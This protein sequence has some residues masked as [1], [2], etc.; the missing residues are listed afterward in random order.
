MI[1]LS[2]L[3]KL[4]AA[5]FFVVTFQV[6]LSKIGW[7]HFGTI[8]FLIVLN[9]I[10]FFLFLSYHTSTKYL[11]QIWAGS[12]ALLAIL[13]GVIA[14]F[15]ANPQTQFALGYVSIILT[16]ITYY[17]YSLSHG[18]TGSFV[19]LLL[20][21]TNL[22]WSWIRNL[23]KLLTQTKPRLV[24]WM[25]VVFA[26]LVFLYTTV[27]I[28]SDSNSQFKLIEIINH[29]LS[30]SLIIFFVA[31]SLG[32]V[33]T[34]SFLKHRLALDLL[35]SAY[36]EALILTTSILIGFLSFSYLRLEHFF[37]INQASNLVA[38]GFK[39]IAAY[40]RQGFI[41]FIIL[42]VIVYTVT[43]IAMLVL[44]YS[45]K[46]NE[47][48]LRSI[49]ILLL[50]SLL[51][52]LSSLTQRFVWYV[53][54]FG[55]TQARIYG[56]MLIVAALVFIMTVTARFV[57]NVYN[58]WQMFE[59]SLFLVLIMLTSLLNLDQ[60]IAMYYLRAAPSSQTK[61]IELTQLSPDSVVGWVESYL[62]ARKTMLELDLLNQV[63]LSAPDRVKL[64]TAKNILTN[65][66][67]HYLYLS[68]QYGSTNNVSILSYEQDTKADNA[69]NSMLEQLAV[70]NLAEWN[71]YRVLNEQ[72]SPQELVQLESLAQKTLLNHQPD[73]VS[74]EL[75]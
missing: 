66:R 52:P 24:I 4:L 29:P 74:Y 63:D 26:T 7:P 71:A 39:S 18:I 41:E 38:F 67:L 42:W 31:L 33:K 13:A 30:G 10:H 62:F 8:G 21:P 51:I 64:E 2:M 32:V 69:D 46:K 22:T 47:L 6:L 34:F 72:I 65:I 70:V 60:L 55:L 28:L 19:D 56:G 43:E 11:R 68:N 50:I 27:S 36:V 45:R 44:H 73:F 37:G 75:E 1:V 57:F 53:S 59:F 48:A 25:V 15:R 54:E 35:S 17:F 61:Y 58:R 12:T 14:L 16:I 40:V 49:C 20:I 9:V 5:F 3:Q 23:K